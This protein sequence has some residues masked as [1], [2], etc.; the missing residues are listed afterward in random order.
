M[1]LPP[2]VSETGVVSVAD[3]IPPPIEQL[4]FTRNCDL[5]KEFYGSWFQR[6]V[7]LGPG[8]DKYALY[9]LPFSDMEPSFFVADSVD[10]KAAEAYFRNALPPEMQNV[11]S[12]GQMLDWE[13][14]LRTNFSQSLP[15]LA[16]LRPPPDS[17]PLEW[18]LNDSYQAPYFTRVIRD[19]GQTCQREACS[20][21]RWDRLIDINGPGMYIVYWF[22]VV[23]MLLASAVVVYELWLTRSRTLRQCRSVRHP[24]YRC[25]RRTLDSI[26]QGAAFFFAAA[27]FALFV[28]YQRKGPHFFPPNDQNIALV[29]SSL[30][31]VMLFWSWRVNRCFA[32]IDLVKG[33]SLVDSQLS[34]LPLVCFVIAVPSV[35]LLQWIRAGTA[36]STSTAIDAFNFDGFSGLICGGVRRHMQIYYETDTPG[37]ANTNPLFITTRLAITVFSYAAARFFWE[38]LAVRSAVARFSPWERF[39]NHYALVVNDALMSPTDP[40]RPLWQRVDRELDSV[41]NAIYQDPRTSAHIWHLGY[42]EMIGSSAV[43]LYA[44]ISYNPWRAV[45]VEWRQSGEEW[46]LGQILA[47]VTLAPTVV[48]LLTSFEFSVAKFPVVVV[49][50]GPLV[51]AGT[52]GQEEV[53]VLVFLRNYKR[54]WVARRLINLYRRQFEGQ[55]HEMNDVI[56][57][58][59]LLPQPVSR[60]G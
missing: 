34:D 50:K 18:F 59:A 40:T 7:E 19:P 37:R 2:G 21:F 25:F 17:G 9:D 3:W 26:I 38:G 56:D 49:E 6:L 44:L 10:S 48:M 22:Q 27:P 14:A 8:E 13:L 12:Y 5:V 58:R 23:S 28:D 46:N 33:G 47:L 54:R 51:G 11:P 24:A 1:S 43:C 31:L 20:S 32:A 41:A 4:N 29:I 35:G 55:G 15:A 36:T 53:N 60:W 45:Q 57:R 39:R 16:A 52:V 30:S 42:G